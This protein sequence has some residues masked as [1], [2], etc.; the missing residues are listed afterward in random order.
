M[1]PSEIT[2]GLR[3]CELFALLSEEELEVLI[4]SLATKW[5]LETYEAG[6]HIFEQGEHS[7]RLYVIADGQVL[8]QRSR[9]IGDRTAMWPLGLLGAYFGAK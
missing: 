7:A 6:D 2:E 8:L 3:T 9:N 1:V 5:L 4:T